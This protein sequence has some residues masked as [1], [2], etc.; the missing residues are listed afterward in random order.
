LEKKLAM[1]NK[2]PVD[3]PNPKIAIAFAVFLIAAV[4]LFLLK[5]MDIF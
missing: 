5:S 3:P 4:L 2:K 1:E